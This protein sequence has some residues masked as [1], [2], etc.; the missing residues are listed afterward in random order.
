MAIFRLIRFP[1]LLVIALAQWLIYTRIFGQAYQVAGLQATLDAMEHL[2]LV[3][4]TIFAAAAGYIVNDL[5]DW[6]IDV[7]NRSPETVIVGRVISEG[8]VRWLYFCFVA[9]GFF[10]SVLLAFWQDKLQL[11]WLYPLACLL[12]AWY[13][14]RFKRSPWMGNVLIA[15]FCAG[16][17]GLVWLS[18]VPQWLQLRKEHLDMQMRVSQVLVVFMVYAL[19]ATW[20]RELVKDLEDQ[21]G[22]EAQGRRTFPIVYGLV[23]TRWFITGLGVLLVLA[24]LGPVLLRWPG[25]LDLSVFVL[26]ASLSAWAV[27]LVWRVYASP[28]AKRYANLSL[29]WKFFL[30]G[31]LFLLFLYQ[32]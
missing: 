9:A 2:L 10:C 32:F 11:L 21:S 14:R 20:I 3:A 25:F 19:L 1:N 28:S 31:G 5:E 24:L 22:D 6:E 8:V 18:E 23:P 26:A 7:V 29:H 13:P 15:V 17:A 30:L 16:T 12:L 4:A 27:L